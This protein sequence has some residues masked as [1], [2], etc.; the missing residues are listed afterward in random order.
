M[1]LGLRE[2]SSPEAPL[3]WR[4]RAEDISHA[5]DHLPEIEAS[6]PWLASRLDDTRVAIL[7]HSMGGHTVSL[8][9][10]MHV[11]DHTT[12]A[13]LDLSDSRIS[14]GIVLAGVGRG[15]DALTA[16][17]IENYAAFGDPDFRPMTKPALIVYGDADQ[18]EHLTVSGPTWHA[19]PYHLA[20]GPK[21]LLTLYGA[22]HG[23]GGVSGYDAAETTDEDP[24]RVEHICRLISANLDFHLGI[25]PDAWRAAVKVFNALAPSVGRIDE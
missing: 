8:L 17:A 4:S 5:L 13:T 10:G 2:E 15:G 25:D 24:A 22:G 12:S 20:P 23:L 18:S 7:G 9:L 21:S 3:Y 1:M 19:D 11:T 14:A 16:T 6:A